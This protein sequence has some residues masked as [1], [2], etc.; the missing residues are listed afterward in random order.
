MNPKL[1]QLGRVAGT[2][3]VVAA[4]LVIGRWLWIHYRVDPWT[5]DGRV[6]ADVVQIAPDVSGLV[7]RVLV[8]TTSRS[9]SATCSSSS[10]ATLPA[11]LDSGGVRS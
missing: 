6:R 5:R 10:T 8:T 11:G 7:T 4:A 9:A 2:C 3:L 1:V